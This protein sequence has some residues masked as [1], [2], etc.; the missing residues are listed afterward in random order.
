[1]EISTSVLMGGLERGYLRAVL[2]DSCGDGVSGEACCVM[3]V[4]LI[5]ETL[6]MFLDGL[7]ADVE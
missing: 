7:D 2:N 3:N 4:E 6:P 1:M 5:H